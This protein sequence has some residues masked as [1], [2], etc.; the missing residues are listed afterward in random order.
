MGHAQ[1]RAREACSDSGFKFFCI[2][3]AKA[4]GVPAKEYA[5]LAHENRIDFQTCHR[6]V[7]RVLWNEG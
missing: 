2:H 5:E 1:E 3:R 7:G 6:Q 4:V